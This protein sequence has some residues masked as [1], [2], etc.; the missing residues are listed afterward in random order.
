MK[1]LIAIFILTWQVSFSQIP[2]PEISPQ[3]TL[4]EQVGYTKFS[5]RYG[6]PAARQR[7]IMGE[8]VPYKKLWRTGAGKCTMIAFDHPV[9]INNKTIPAGAYAL[10]T[11]PDEREWTVMLNSDTTKLY[12]DPSEYDLKTEVIAFKV[13]PR[14]SDRYYESLTLLLD[15]VKYDAVFYLTW[16]NT[17]ISFPIK[18]LS[19]E[20]ALSEITKSIKANP[21]DPERLSQAAWFYYMN[22]DDPQQMLVWIDKALESGDDRWLLR[23]RFDVL[24]RMEKYDEAARAATRAI[25]FLKTTKPISWEEGVRDYQERIQRWPKHAQRAID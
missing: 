19:Y 23:Q 15:I 1:Y 21:T 12:G 10:L 22:N 16:E 18:T 7:K 6:R 20:T 17:Q 4:V 11:I 13:I 25:T 5:I 2:L 14:K 3:A 24:E 9:V 8:L